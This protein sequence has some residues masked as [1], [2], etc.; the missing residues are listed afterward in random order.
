MNEAES[1]QSLA[2]FLGQPG[3][4]AANQ[5]TAAV[6]GMAAVAADFQATGQDSQVVAGRIA[7]VSYGGNTFQLLGYTGQANLARY[8]GAFSQAIQSFNRLTDPAALA[9]QPVRLTLVRLSKD[10]T[11][12]EFNRQYPSAV[13]PT[14]VAFLNGVGAVT[15]V[16]KAG[17]LARRVQ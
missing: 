1:G 15:D 14:T 11:V 5:A 9:K 6:N 4:Q 2:K 10:M 7:F 17:T 16:L 3:I 13:P 8:R 12:D